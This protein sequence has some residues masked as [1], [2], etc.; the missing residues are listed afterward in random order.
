MQINEGRSTSE[1]RSETTIVE[2]AFARID[3]ALSELDAT[4][5]ATERTF[6]GTLRPNIPQQE[7]GV[8]AELREADQSL[9][10]GSLLAILNRVERMNRQLAAINERSTL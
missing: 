6:D 9:L 1:V 3:T 2:R 8:G 10:H 5:G 4:I 7:K